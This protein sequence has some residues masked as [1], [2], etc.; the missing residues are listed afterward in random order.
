IPLFFGLGRLLPDVSLGDALVGLAVG[1]LG[2][3]AL[4]AL[5]RLVLHRDA[6]GGGDAK[7]L[8]LVGG[9][10]G[11]RALPWALVGGAF[12][13]ALVFVPLVVARWWRARRAA[14][15]AP[16]ASL[17]RIAVPFG[18]FLAAGALAYLF[19]A[20]PLHAWLLARL[21]GE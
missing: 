14:D 13:G 17:G 19:L 15:R 6:L 11:W 2:V 16:F 7:L 8:A 1:Y 9:F 18:P 20:R 3:T 21:A 4:D 5:W 12:L 10:L